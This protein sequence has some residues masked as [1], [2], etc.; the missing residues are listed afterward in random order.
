M[1]ACVVAANEDAYQSV[2]RVLRSKLNQLPKIEPAP[3]EANPSR[4]LI[5]LLTAATKEQKKRGEAYL[6][7]DVLL[8]QLIDHV[9]YLS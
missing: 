2:V 3:M 5:K 8:S 1:Q 9:R 7:V 4:D 6:G